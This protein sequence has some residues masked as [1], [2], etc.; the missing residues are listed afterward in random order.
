LWTLADKDPEYLKAIENLTK[1]DITSIPS[2]NGKATFIPLMSESQR[3]QYL[4]DQ[5]PVWKKFNERLKEIMK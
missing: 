5:Q 4:H 1:E 3:D 2:G